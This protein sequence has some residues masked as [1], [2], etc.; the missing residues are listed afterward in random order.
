M[1]SI[2]PLREPPHITSHKEH[3]V[4]SAL[5]AMQRQANPKDLSYWEMIETTPYYAYGV[6]AL[7]VNS[8]KFAGRTNSMTF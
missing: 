1:Q 8:S 3:Q 5:M 6:R 4:F 7:V 2:D